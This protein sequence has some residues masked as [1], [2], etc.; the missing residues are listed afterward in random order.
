MGFY[1]AGYAA[2]EFFVGLFVGHQEI[3][4]GGDFGVERDEAAGG[5]D[6]ERD[7][8]FGE[9]L[10]VGAAVDEDGEEGGDAMGAA[11]IA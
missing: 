2:G 10:V 6:V 11:F 9:R 4:R 7:G 5:A 8:V 1:Y 3:L